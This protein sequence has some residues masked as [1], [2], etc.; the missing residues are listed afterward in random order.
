MPTDISN[1]LGTARQFTPQPDNQYQGRYQ[2]IVA[3]RVSPHDTSRSATLANNMERL[4]VAL[5]GYAV[6]HEKY[7]NDTGAVAADKFIN[8]KNPEDLKRINIIDAAQQEGYAD[9]MANPYFMAHAEDLRGQLLAKQLKTEYDNQYAMTPAKSMAEEQERY[10]KFLSDWRENNLT[11][12]HAPANLNAFNKGFYEAQ[13]LNMLKLTSDWTQKKYK[14][15]VLTTMASAQS[16]LGDVIENSVE[17]LKTNGAM[18]KSVQEIFNE[19]RLMGLPPEYRVKLLDDFATQIIQTGHLDAKRLEQM[20]DNITVQTSMDGTITK[21][22]DLLNMQTYKTYAVAFQKQFMDK[23]KWNTIDKF[24]KMGQKG[25]DEVFKA[26][27][28]VK[29]NDPDNASIWAEITPAVIT[30]VKRNEEEKKA[31]ARAM[32]SAR[33]QAGENAIKSQN[34]IGAINTWLNNGTMY[35]GQTISSLS[36]DKEEL[37][38]IIPN[39]LQGLIAQGDVKKAMRLMDMPQMNAL[40][41]DISAD[42]AYKLDCITPDNVDS[43]DQSIIS[44]LQFTANNP[45]SVERI[46]G[47]EV[48]N[49]ARILRSLFDFHNG[50]MSAT[51]KDFAVYNIADKDKKEGYKQ[52]THNILISTGYKVGGVTHLTDDDGGANNYYPSTTI[53]IAG[54][55]EFESAV[56]NLATLFCLQ[57]LS[58]WDA[59]NK[60][61]ATI[62]NNYLVY[63]TGA[64]PKGVT[65]DNCYGATEWQN[66]VYF[67]RA[68]AEKVLNNSPD[69]GWNVTVTYLRE[70]Q[71]FSF[72]NEVTNN[73]TYVSLSDIRELARDKWNKDMQWK[74]DNPNTEYT[75]S[76]STGYDVTSINEQRNRLA[77]NVYNHSHGSGLH[78]PI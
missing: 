25:I 65:L 43:V 5:Q 11:G 31:N 47:S 57:G 53:D 45:N 46:F 50:D 48:G 37:N 2:S 4:N 34:M 13:P 36:I 12:V 63:H 24:A 42:V 67:R 14:E 61:G 27:A 76:N 7:L 71:N 73:T 59:V 20:M 49:R 28:W 1:T 77:N 17:L 55:P 70:S 33:K 26:Q 56:N 74:N 3:S 19:V 23:W 8:S 29:E 35:N 10:N 51:L 41:N 40:R 16:K 44:L 22:S 18:T 69:D 15:D 75:S 6:N 58:P 38:R 32:L 54:N 39:I 62:S 72:T 78:R 21:A 68:L 30:Q 9:V 60:A 52:Q 64:F 66:E